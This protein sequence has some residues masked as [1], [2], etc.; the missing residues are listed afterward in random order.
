MGTFPWPEQISVK[1]HTNDQ[2]SIGLLNGADNDQQGINH[3]VHFV[4]NLLNENDGIASLI[5]II[6][7]FFLIG[8]E[9]QKLHGETYAQLTAS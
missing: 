8:K 3:V 7:L 2:A 4:S 9:E 6:E 5:G 1:S